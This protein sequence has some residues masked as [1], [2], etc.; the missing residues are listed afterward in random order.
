MVRSTASDANKGSTWELVRDASVFQVKLLID[1]M[2]D[3]V[4]VPASL[5]AGVIS[6]IKSENGHPGPQFYKV[7]SMGQQSE[8]WINLFGALRNAPAGVEKENRFG[9]TD[10]DDLI[11]RVENFVADEYRRGGVTAQARQ[12]IADVLAAMRGDKGDG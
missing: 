7:V 12:R 3:L 9:D 1:G 10:I 5:V 4:L 2:R 11:A 8:R 6:L